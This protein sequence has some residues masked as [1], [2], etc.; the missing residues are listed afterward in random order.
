MEWEIGAPFPAGSAGVLGFFYFEE[1]IN[2][3]QG[4]A[5]R[6]SL[7]QRLNGFPLSIIDVNLSM[8]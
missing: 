5:M 6:I 3:N 7:P 2:P 1:A 4:N 8:F